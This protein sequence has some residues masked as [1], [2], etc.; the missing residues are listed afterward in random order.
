MVPARKRGT[1]F[2]PDDAE[3]VTPLL[4]ANVIMMGP[5]SPTYAVRQLQGSVAW[6]T[7][8]ARH[9]LGADLVFAWL[10]VRGRRF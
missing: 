8:N 10:F 7:V 5:G 2:S 1:P 4:E 6:H 3:I 9:R